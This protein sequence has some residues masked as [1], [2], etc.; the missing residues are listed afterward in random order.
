MEHPDYF[1]VMGLGMTAQALF[2]ARFIIQLTKSEL[3]GKVVSPALFWQLSLLASLILMIYGFLRND[4]VIIGGQVV[5]YYIYIRNLQLKDQWKRLIYP[6]RMIFLITPPALLFALLIFS[7]ESLNGLFSNPDIPVFLLTYGGIGQLVFTL[8]FVVQW[9]H[10]ENK[11][12]SEFPLSFWIISITGS[13]LIIG[14]AIM[15][16]DA[17][18]FIGQVLGTLVYSRNIYLHYSR[19]ALVKR[20]SFSIL[21]QLKHHRM[22][23]LGVLI[24]M[25]LFANLNDWSVT[26]STEARYAQISKEMLESKDYLHPTLMGIQH[27]HKPPL[28]YWVTVVAYKLFG[29]SGFSA[30]FF[31]QIA[32]ILQV[33]IVYG[34]GRSLLKSRKLAF[35][36]ALLYFALPG[37]YMSSR[38]LTTDVY[39][40]SF[41][42][43][44]VFAWLRYTLYG[45]KFFVLLFYLSLG[46]G[47]LTKGP[48]VFVFPVF[49]V[50]GTYLAGVRPPK[51]A[52]Y[53]LAGIAVMLVVG[54]AW[55]VY[56]ILL[57]KQFIDYFLIRHTLERFATDVFRRSEPWWYFPAVIIASSFPWGIMLL[58]RLF[59][60]PSF[61]SAKGIIFL[62]WIVPGV[63][64]FSLSASKLMLYVLPVYAGLAIGAIWAWVRMSRRQKSIWARI[65]LIYQLVVLLGL[66]F[67]PLVESN[68]FLSWEVYSL[69]IMTVGVLIA[70]RY[71][72]II[73]REKPIL[74]AAVFMYGLSL[75]TPHIFEHNP[76][77][78]KDSRY[79]AAFIENELPETENI[80][81]FDRRLPSI[82]FH[83]DTNVISLYVGDHNLNRETQFES[84]DQWKE[85]LINLRENPEKLSELIQA[86]NVLLLRSSR[87]PPEHFLEDLQ[88]FDQVTSIDGWDIYYF[89]R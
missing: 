60:S 78:I 81:I 8:R 72:P 17:V 13:L 77:K 48:V 21:E 16:Q 83:T 36:A 14:Y 39:L 43:L 62:M 10:S 85:N 32:I 4:I 69:A 41:V 88:A 71:A 49:F 42:L 54:L 37:V 3:A 11:K 46:L 22:A 38:A 26:E 52:F 12:E 50:A 24:A 70:L 18:I 65:Q 58:I 44:S 80:L 63:F 25:A 87:Q 23:I 15:R 7:P 55:F 68:L 20:S 27:Y 74:S 64:F 57:D 51:Q 5:A 30:R 35:L 66:F 61:R 89:E 84:N 28:T 56:L 19:P 29:V 73:A 59:R 6:L 45:Q 33:M 86:D 40:T 34:I 79:I 53:H 1:L 2:S 9:L 47:F 82:P 67:I 76:E 75:I 31:L